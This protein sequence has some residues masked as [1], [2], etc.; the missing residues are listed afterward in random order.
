VRNGAGVRCPT[1][2]RLP[3]DWRWYIGAMAATAI[4]F[5]LIIAGIRLGWGTS[6]ARWISL[7]MQ[8]G[9]QL[10]ISFALNIAW[11]PAGRRRKRQSRPLHRLRLRPPRQPRAVPRMRQYGSATF[12]VYIMFRSLYL[13]AR[14]D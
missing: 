5:L 3:Q 10:L 7:T 1:M 11:I 8:I 2:R 12:F 4:G 14:H 9:E 6:M 13:Q